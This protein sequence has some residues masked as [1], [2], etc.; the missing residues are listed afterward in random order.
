MTYRDRQLEVARWDL[1]VTEAS[2]HIHNELHGPTGNSVQAAEIQG[3]VHVYQ[4][5]VSALPIP[6]QLPPAVT[7]FTGRG[8][9]VDQLDALLAGDSTCRPKAAVIS[10]IAGTAGVGKT[11][12]AVHWGHRVRDQFPDGQLYVNLRGFDSAIPLSPEQV[13]DGF[14]RALDIPVQKIPKDI[15]ALTGLYRAVLSNRRVLVVLDNAKSAEQVRPLLPNSQNCMVIVTSRN[16]LAGLVARDGATRI[17][18]DLLT[19]NDALAL[20]RR[21]IGG[22]RVE[23]EPTAAAELVKRCAC[24]PLALRIT[25]ERIATRPHLPLTQLAAE[26]ASEQHRLN[27]LAADDDEDTAIRAVFSW[28]YQALS[29]DAA[30][31]FRLLALHVGTSVSVATAA[32]LTACTVAEVRY[33]LETLNSVHLIEE[34]DH[35]RY[36]YHDLLRAYAAERVR[37]EDVDEERARAIV[38][39]LRWYLY[40]AN[41]ACRTL[42]PQRAALVLD[43]PTD[44]CHPQLFH[45]AREA[46]RWCRIERTNLVAAVQRA[47]TIEEYAIAWTLPVVLWDFFYL[48]MHSADWI[49]AHSIGVKGAAQIRDRHG[50]AWSLVGLGLAHCRHETFEQAL[51]YVERGMSV[52][53]ELKDK[54]IGSFAMHVTGNI[55]M[56]RGDLEGAVRHYQSALA[57]HRELGDRWWEA[58]T[59]GNLAAAHWKL[60]QIKKSIEYAR[61]AISLSRAISDQWIEGMALLYLGEANRKLGRLSDSMACAQRALVIH[62]EFG[63]RWGEAH[64]LYSLGKTASVM[65]QLSVV[66]PYWREALE[67]FEEISVSDAIKVRTRL[68]ALEAQLGR[69]K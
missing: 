23:A 69:E 8:E 44:D 39:M 17:A 63:H 31:V 64:A 10:A 21:I 25:A 61:R 50:E 6:C 5:M 15:Q 14:L 22:H 67:I 4:T 11:A 34:S 45:H 59:L 36:R 47:M 43:A 68:R 65:G 41:N 60:R 54:Q 32:A 19:P 52:A 1:Q 66:R 12:L 49:T 30:R 35:G 28:S 37:V 42:I 16:R 58:A 51:D 56:A 40:T 53:R 55:H 27:V 3:G 13:L 24:L 29:P 7:H 20:L 9:D 57:A 18:L 62:R 38:R 2:G 33:S 26:L 48:D 46:L